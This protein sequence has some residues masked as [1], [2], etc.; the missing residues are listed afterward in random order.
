[1]PVPVTVSGKPASRLGRRPKRL[2]EVG[3][4]GSG[5]S[6]TGNLPI[7][8]YPSQQDMNRMRMEDLQ[9]VLHKSGTLKEDL[10]QAFLSAAKASFQEHSKTGEKAKGHDFHMEQRTV[11]MMVGGQNQPLMSVAGGGIPVSSPSL[12]SR[13]GS[14]DLSGPGVSGGG[15]GRMEVVDSPSSLQSPGGSCMTDFN[16][17]ALDSF[18]FEQGL[19]GTPGGSSQQMLL[20]TVG[21]LA[22]SSPYNP[23]GAVSLD[24]VSGAASPQSDTGLGSPLILP[25]PS[26]TLTTTTTTANGTGVLGSDTS[27]HVQHSSGPRNNGMLNQGLQST[28]QGAPPP[29][30]PPIPIS[31]SGLVQYPHS[32]PH[33]LPVSTAYGMSAGHSEM[34]VDIKIE[35][36]AGYPSSCSVKSEPVS[37]RT[38]CTNR[39]FKFTSKTLTDDGGFDPLVVRAI[40][41]EAR[42]IP[43]ETRR[44]LIEQVTDAVVEAHVQTTINTHKSI[45][46][47]NMKLQKEFLDGGPDASSEKLK[48][49]AAFMWQQFVSAMVPEITKVVKFCKKLPGFV[50]IE[51]DDQIRLIKQGAFEVMVT[52]YSLLV[53]T[54]KETLLDPTLTTKCHR[55][56]ILA[57]PM[58]QFLDEFFYVAA[59]FNPLK[60]TDGE[61]GLFTSILIV[62]PNRKGL[63]NK[64]AIGKIQSLYQQALYILMKHNHPDADERFTRLMELT[65]MLQRINEEHFKAIN[66]IRLTL[67]ESA[68]F[69]DLHREVFDNSH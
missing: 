52:R 13:S 10:M 15:G 30:L 50:E 68:Q 21:D 26:S 19:P 47:A 53:D 8:P 39:M 65:G 32:L 1:M 55:R 45:E 40:L 38:P 63:K 9:K 20:D 58:G 64:M 17:V 29:P 28:T 4:E 49:D 23:G 33:P 36:S 3:G 67:P 6:R 62:C 12:E 11:A 7:A 42:Q 2:K 14:A 69:P 35:P 46:E 31:S 59:N 43:S 5:G 18:L 27:S 61:V 51:Q 44:L 37:P 57:T 25:S 34:K 56:V 66:N 24:S 54:D 60:L 48:A 22:L 41:K 16:L